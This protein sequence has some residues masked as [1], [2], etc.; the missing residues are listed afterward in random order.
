MSVLK[1]VVKHVV[2]FVEKHGAAKVLDALEGTVDVGLDKLVDQVPD[3]FKLL[4]KTADDVAKTRLQAYVK[5]LEAKLQPPTDGAP[6][7]HEVRG[8]SA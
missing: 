8:D 4:A 7:E 2:H 3:E 5:L 1:E 6:A